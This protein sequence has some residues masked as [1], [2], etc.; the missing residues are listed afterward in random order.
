MQEFQTSFQMMVQ[1]YLSEHGNG[2]NFINNYLNFCK[3]EPKNDEEKMIINYYRTKADNYQ[4]NLFN[5]LVILNT[6]IPSMGLQNVGATCYMNA[7]L[8][9]LIHIKELSEL[10]LSAFF[11]KY[12]KEDAN[13]IKDH[14]LS[15]EY[16]NILLNVFYPK[17]YGNELN[18]F[19]PHKFKQLVGELNPLFSGFMANDAKDLLQFILERMHSELKMAMTF[20]MN[21]QY[22]QRDERQSLEYFFN[23]YVYQSNSPILHYLYGITKIKTTCCKCQTTKYNFQSYNLLYF[24][25]KES[26]R[27]AVELKK[28][29][30][31]NFDE[32]KYTLNLEDCFIYN[33]KVDHFSGDN[34]MFCNVC[35]DCFDADYQ[36][37]LFNTPPVLSIVLNRGKANKDFQEPF[38]FGTEL[39]IEKYLHNQEKKGKYYLIGMVIHYGE[40]SMSGHFIAYCR[41]DKNSKWFC[42]NDAYVSECENFDEIIKRGVPYILFYHQE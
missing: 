36:S 40:S 12:P 13:F 28:A 4:P 10:F 34:A 37:M 5:G 1:K 33:E 29:S 17:L 23:S 3:L 41:M 31:K 27:Y 42:Y 30:D 16:V 8:Q 15:S 25:L 7:T 14:L 19:A 32:K 11:T 18:C 6:Q 2:N 35:R 22:D 26:K 38:I 39:N 24:P 9:C 20:F 21:Y